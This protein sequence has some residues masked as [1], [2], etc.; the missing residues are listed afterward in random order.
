[1][2]AAFAM[3]QVD[4]LFQDGR[5]EIGQHAMTQIEDVAVMSAVAG[6]DVSHRLGDRWPGGEA[7]HRVEVSLQDRVGAE[8]PRL[9]EDHR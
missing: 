9:G 2:G 8:P 1:M 4:D 5:V 7:H 3:H 6:Q